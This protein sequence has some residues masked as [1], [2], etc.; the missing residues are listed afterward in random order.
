MK[1]SRVWKRK[2]F[3][4]RRPNYIAAEWQCATWLHQ[5]VC[6]LLFMKCFVPLTTDKE[7]ENLFYYVFISR[8]WGR[9]QQS[10]ILEH[11][12]WVKVFYWLFRCTSKTGAHTAFMLFR[13]SNLFSDWIH[14]L[15][16]TLVCV[17]CVDHWNQL[18]CWAEKHIG[19]PWNWLGARDIQKMAISLAAC[20]KLQI[21]DMTQ[22]PPL[23]LPQGEALPFHFHFV[24]SKY[25]SFFSPCV[26]VWKNIWS[27]AQQPVSKLSVNCT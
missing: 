20:M 8:I 15:A 14:W 19:P 22:A 5:N 13:P 1:K 27:R 6:L 12:L 10:V 2:Q 18:L 25:F 26:F 11:N 21:W 16:A 7:M 23:V 9:V 3:C 24:E 17:V 4:F